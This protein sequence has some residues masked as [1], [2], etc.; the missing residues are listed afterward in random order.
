MDL[1]AGKIDIIGRSAQAFQQSQK[2]LM[3]I[4]EARRK[5]EKDKEDLD[6]TRKEREFKLEKMKR[7]G[8]SSELEYE[9]QKAIADQYA[10]QEKQ[11]LEGQYA[12]VKSA[13]NEQMG[14][15]RQATQL[16]N[17]VL[18]SDPNDAEKIMAILNASA[19]NEARKTELRP[20]MTYGRAGFETVDLQKEREETEER[21]LDMQL[22]RKSL[23]DK[24]DPLKEEE[25]KLDIDIKRNKLNG[26]EKADYNRKDVIAHADKLYENRPVDDKRPFSAFL[27]ESE[28]LFRGNSDGNSEG[29]TLENKPSVSKA[30]GSK[31][32]DKM[33]SLIEG[34]MKKYGR[35]R[36]EVIGAMKKKGLLK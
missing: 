21:G 20:K 22:K 7:E 26:K 12:L 5:I 15:A 36:E 14:V 11:K 30:S 29:V 1:L 32:N 23:L 17:N 16:R 24:E 31:Y 10:K 27:K 13:E 4:S 2:N 34:S 35:S 8:Q 19:R 18:R 25:K 9:T 33:E 6:F 3:A 28:D